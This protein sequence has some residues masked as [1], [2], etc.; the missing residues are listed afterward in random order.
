MSGPKAADVQPKLRRAVE[1]IGKQVDQA[2]RNAERLSKIEAV[3][4]DAGIRATEEIE[5]K[6]AANPLTD[7]IR[8]HAS[9]EVSALERQRAVFREKMELARREQE[10]AAEL[11]REA[12]RLHNQA[13]QLLR[14][15]VSAA[16]T[17]AR[18][19]ATSFGWDLRIEDRKA[20]QARQQAKE[21][22]RLER[23]ASESIRRALD[24]KKNAKSAYDAARVLGRQHLEKFN[25]VSTQ[26]AE[27]EKAERIAEENQRNAMAGKSGTDALLA[28]IHGLR[29]EKFAP[30]ELA[31]LQPAV[32]EFRGAFDRKDYA[33]AA[34]I[35]SGLLP[36]LRTLEQKVMQRQNEFDAAMLSAQNALKAARE[37]ISVLDRNE[38]IRWTAEEQAVN[39]AFDA[40]SGAEER[41]A[42]EQFGEAEAL[43]GPS[44][45]AIRKFAAAAEERSNAAAQRMELAEV[46]MNALYE[47]GYDSPTYYY[48]QQNA[49]GADVEFSDL[50]IFAKAPGVRGDMRMNIDLDGKVRLEVE[51][52]A[53]G[54]EAACHQLV[55]D[56]QK[57]V[58]DEIDFVMTDWGRAAG[59][60][61]EAKVA[62]REQIRT[63]EKTR[64]R[65]KNG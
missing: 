62:I 31:A 54:E 36:R 29:H 9:E 46:I 11:R 49:A 13:D 52:I 35:S 38:L 4:L 22:L 55:T 21:A 2:R 50:T 43:I 61:S 41:I 57:G 32:A 40:I 48:A 19:L 25:S 60:D 24:H 26:A 44:L 27:Q 23:A 12:V 7:T 17:A 20:T 8:R 47:Q 6:V 53:E 33:A 39:N 34:E 65:Q 10:K 3:D 58:G 5:R 45:E 64:E 16:Q 59:I 51:G 30:G 28:S 63:Q 37:E 15:A 42:A 1:E 56:L 18:G 14:G